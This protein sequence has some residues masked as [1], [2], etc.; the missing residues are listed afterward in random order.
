M[1]SFY[2]LIAALWSCSVVFAQAPAA[3]APPAGMAQTGSRIAG[4]VID[5]L[6]GKPVEYATVSLARWGTTKNIN[7][8][9]TDGK[10]NFKIANVTPGQYKLTVSFMGYQAK[11]V[12]VTAEAGKLEQNAGKLLL[13]PSA[14]VL[15]EVAVTGEVPVVENRVDKVV[16]NAE[17]DATVSGGN[18]GDVLRKVPMVSVDQDGNISLRGNQNVRILINGKPTGAVAASAADAMRMLPADQIKNVEVITSPSAKYDAE[19]SGGIINIITKKKEMSG[20]SGSISGG[21]GTRQNNGNANLNVN[22]NKLS[23]TTNF[24]GNATWPQTTNL[25]F[26]SFTP[27]SGTEQLQRGNSRTSRYGYMASGNVSYDFN[28]FNSLSTGI[29]LNEGRFKTDGTTSNSRS[30]N[31]VA[32]EAYERDNYNKTKFGGFDWNADYTHKF[33]TQGHELSLAGQWSHSL[34]NTDFFTLYSSDVFAD[35]RGDNHAKNDEYTAQL[36]YTLPLSKVVKIEAGGKGIFRDI[37]S[38]SNFYTVAG[39]GFVF[40]DLLSNVYTYN[41]DVY[42]GYTVL[43]LQMSKT[44]GLQVGGRVEYTDIEGRSENAAS[45]VAPASNDYTNFIPSFAISKTLKNFQ[46][47]RFSYSKR[48]Q[49]PSLQFLNP[50]R[51]VSNEQSQRQGNPQLAPEVTHSLE[52]NYSAMPSPGSMINTSVYFRHTTDIIESFAKPDTY[53]GKEVVFTTYDNTGD[54]NSFGASLYGSVNPVKNLTLRGNV[55]VFTYKP[56]ASNAFTDYAATS[57]TYAQYKAFISGSFNFPA[58]FVAETFMILNSPRRTFQGENPSF[59]MWVMSFNK[60]FLNKKAKIGINV[61][62]PFNENKHFRSKVNTGRLVQESD[63]SIPFRSVGINFSYSFGKV[64]FTPQPRKKRGVN[65]DD[66][67]QDNGQGGQGGQGMG[68]GN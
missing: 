52:L 50:F 60:Q 43:S 22:K 44:V 68:S 28:D 57:K 67:K 37:K 30:D 66:L 62:D 15:K 14:N 35:V 48:I 33:K 4:Q 16:Y 6:S 64:N 49:R 20:V 47:V 65:N 25:F 12:K 5:S 40:D 19:G 9:L 41:Q 61:V 63:F 46:S 23:V 24:G 32:L 58:N 26:N 54:N 8:A 56:T 53:N 34:N 18:A 42:A 59:S 10:G 11:S 21:V 29:R 3:G 1:K 36:D 55:D 51:D 45:G 13:L 2:L 31:S 17:K 7:G 27:S 38:P 39:D